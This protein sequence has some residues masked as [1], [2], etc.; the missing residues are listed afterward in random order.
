MPGVVGES[1]FVTSDVESQL[2]ATEAVQRAIA[3]SY[4]RAVERF[5]Q[6][7]PGG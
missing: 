3:D 2:L 4:K 5:F 1:L 7:T 6:Q